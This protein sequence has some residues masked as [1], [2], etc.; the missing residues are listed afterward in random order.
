MSN[1]N[2]DYYKRVYNKVNASD[3]LKERLTD[4]RGK[5]DREGKKK[6]RMTWKAAAVAAA[7]LV[8]VVPTGVYAATHWGM[9]D[10]FSSTGRSLPQEAKQL[11]E[12]EIPQSKREEANQEIPV[13]FTVRE[14]LCDSGSV[15]LVIEAKAKESGKYFLV[16]QDCQET[17]C[18]SD[19]GIEGEETIGEYA[20]RKGLDILYVGTGF[21][22]DSP[23]CPGTCGISSKSVQDDIL[24]IGITAERTEDQKE[25]KTIMT[26][27]VRASGSK[28]GLKSVT[29]FELKDN[30]K[31]KAVLYTSGDEMKIAGTSAKVTKVLMEETEV[32]TYVKVYFTASKAVENDGLSFRIKDTESSDEWDL[33]EGG[34]VKTLKDGSY[35]ARFTYNK[36]Q[37][38]EKCVLE[39]YDCLEKEI[40][41]HIELSKE[42]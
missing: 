6:G 2:K 41:G 26:N 1:T 34:G 9:N 8:V 20:K 24:E 18:V 10:F 36:K 3:E 13:E 23:F 5:Y 15:S 42:K 14:S 39:A 16:G 11:I 30:S 27:T 35:C 29:A 25:L 7:A 22:H 38:P 17:D 12:T 40:F 37:L 33:Y 4:M 28:E 19:L 21:R 32:N 31:S